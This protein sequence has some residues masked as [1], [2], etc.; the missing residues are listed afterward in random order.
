MK[1]G[2]RVMDSDIHVLE[3]SGFWAEYLDPRFRDRAPKAGGPGS[4]VLELEGKP[5]PAFL[6]RPERQ[7]AWRL[8]MRRALAQEATNEQLKAA[9]RRRGDQPLLCRSSRYDQRRSL[10]N[11]STEAATHLRPGR[12]TAGQSSQAARCI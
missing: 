5:I 12:Q 9:S 8:R 6:D 7:R 4:V 1:Q 3:P 2:L 11:D 10:G